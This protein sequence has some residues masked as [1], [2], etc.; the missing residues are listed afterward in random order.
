MLRI[1]RERAGLWPVLSSVVNHVRTGPTVGIT[2]Q[3]IGPTREKLMAIT[4]H[5][6]H[7]TRA[8]SGRLAGVAA[9]ACAASLLAYAPTASATQLGNPSLGPGASAIQTSSALWYIV[10]NPS[11]AKPRGDQTVPDGRTMP[12]GW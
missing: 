11:I 10:H 1:E 4:T 3:P 7:T 8:H 9:L 12:V 6:Q 5:Q 2:D